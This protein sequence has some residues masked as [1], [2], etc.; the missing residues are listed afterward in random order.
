MSDSLRSILCLLDSHH[1]PWWTYEYVEHWQRGQLE[2][3]LAAGLLVP[4]GYASTAS[5]PGCSETA[6]VTLV[7]NKVDQKSEACLSCGQ[8]GCCRVPLDHVS[9]WRLD[10]SLF[11]DRLCEA[12]DAAGDREEIV[13]GRVW[14]LGKCYWAGASRSVYFGRRL[15]RLDSSQVIRRV[16]FSAGAV[17]LVPSAGPRAELELPNLPTI[18]RLVDVLSWRATDF[19]LDHVHVNDQLSAIQSRPVRAGKRASRLS[20]IERLKHE[21]VAHL[22]AARDHAIATRDRSGQADLLPRPTHDLLARQL[23]VSRPTITRCFEDKAAGE[24]RRLWELAG[25]VERLLR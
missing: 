6:E 25:D 12:I 9:C 11:L 17:L 1:D 13:R 2:Q 10:F 7:T 19:S 15:Q 3:C 20:V 8:C 22:R 16:G 4:A 21:L 5:C 18:V 24:V 23:K 14:R